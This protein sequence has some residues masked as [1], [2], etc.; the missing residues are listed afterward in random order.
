MLQYRRI[1]EI[2]RSEDANDEQ[3]VEKIAE[4]MRSFNLLCQLDDVRDETQSLL[5]NFAT[6]MMESG[7]FRPSDM[8]RIRN[9]FYE[10]F[11]ALMVVDEELE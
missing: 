4:L 10:T 1:V 7:V 2:A 11:A 9:E 5:E 3:K 6:F 8:P